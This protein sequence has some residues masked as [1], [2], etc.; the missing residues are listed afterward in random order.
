MLIGGEKVAGITSEDRVR[1]K[2]SVNIVDIID[3]FVSLKKQ[4]KSYFGYCP[5]HDERTPS[6]AVTAEKQLFKCFSCGRSG[7]VFSFFMEKDGLSFNEAV[8]K[9][10][11]LGNVPLQIDA[12][13]L[14]NRVKTETEI[15]HDNIIHMHEL[16]ADL[17]YHILKNT[18]EGERALK[19]VHA[20][21]LTDETIDQFKIGVALEHRDMVVS[22]LRQHQFKDEDIIVSGLVVQYNGQLLDRFSQRIMVPLRN[23]K[24]QVVAFSGRTYLE[25]STSED[26]QKQPKYLNS[27]ETVLFHKGTFLFNLDL[28]RGAIRKQSQ[29][30]LCEGYMDVI[31]SYQAGITNAIA[32]MGTSLT[33]AQIN[34]MKRLSQEVV[35]AYDGDNA[36][37][38][39]TERAIELLRQ[40]PTITI[41]VVPMLENMDPDDM[42]RQKGGEYY[43]EF[44]LTHR[45]T[46]FQFYR[47]FY[48]KQFHLSNQKDVLAYVDL[49]LKELVKEPSLTARAIFLKELSEEFRIDLKALEEQF[50][51]FLKQDNK[52]SKA[53]DNYKQSEPLEFRY[54]QSESMTEKGY[55]E[56]LLLQRL[57]TDG[58]TESMIVTIDEHFHFDNVAYQTILLLYQGYRSENQGNL[59]HFSE[60]LDNVEMRQLVM[61]A[62]SA[63]LPTEVSE[64]E[65]SDLL[66]RLNDCRKKE[67]LEIVKANIKEAQM[68]NDKNQ[69]EYWLLEYLKLMKK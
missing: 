61:K 56:W 1:V 22:L 30:I 52:K 40:H 62:T 16:V 68:A 3:Q 2:E 55:V 25:Q 42:I 4:G 32:S 46:A 19:Y 47:R 14:E 28:A 48:K 6:F 26:A 35:I 58:K 23:E 65:I 50:H 15:L 63:A 8:V 39:A 43:K 11:E 31:A 13:A 7:D 33:D 44:V 17:Y 53:I 21:G 34:Q 12:N 20:R 38:K 29:A 54:Q 5:F 67:Q 36:G 57:L 69:E 51:I 59:H 9:V 64:Q 18:N 27:P 41:S 49:L 66:K 45:E 24:G 37:L 10:A 60:S